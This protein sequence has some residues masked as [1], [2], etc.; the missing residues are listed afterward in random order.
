MFHSDKSGP[1]LLPESPSTLPSGQRALRQQLSA[2]LSRIVFEAP[3]ARVGLELALCATFFIILYAAV[4]WRAFAEDIRWHP[5]LSWFSAC[6]L[7]ALVDQVLCSRP[8]QTLRR[9]RKLA[10]TGNY[11]GALETLT[12]VEPAGTAF[13][14]CPTSVYCFHR[15]EILIQAGRTEEAREELTQAR[16]A[17]MPD[18]L[19]HL[20]R[21]KLFRSEGRFDEA[22]R[23]LDEACINA[24]KNPL[25]VLERGLTLLEQRQDFRSARDEFDRVL[26]MPP[27]LHPSGESTHELA[28][29]FGSVA[30]LRTGQA[31][32]GLENLSRAIARIRSAAGFSLSLRPTLAWLYMERAFYFATHREPDA[33]VHDLRLA[34]SI[35]RYPQIAL[36][37]ADVGEELACRYQIKPIEL[38]SFS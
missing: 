7:T 13:L 26:E 38:L 20:S 16:S 9:A 6:L 33:A 12:L 23:E 14:R 18:Y 15:A 8:L 30:R 27:V 36:R 3:A 31:E 29:A 34:V 25:V 17:G 32:E 37:A 1:S 4:P 2:F 10:L 24:P 5:L 35:C 19:F 22:T 21:C 28:L 11:E